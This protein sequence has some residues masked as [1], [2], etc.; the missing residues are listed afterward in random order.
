MPLFLFSYFLIFFCFKQSGWQATA[1]QSQKAITT[2]RRPFHKAISNAD[3]ESDI[4]K[5][6]AQGQYTKFQTSCFWEGYDTAYSN[7]PKQV[8]Q[9]LES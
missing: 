1:T 6:A 9:F 8:Q 5:A 2:V 3:R 7:V 4:P